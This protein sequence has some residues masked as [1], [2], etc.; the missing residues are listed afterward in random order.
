MIGHAHARSARPAR[1]GESWRAWAACRGV[2]TER[3]YPSAEA[4]EAIEG[5]RKVCD[6]CPVRP[7]CLEYALE[8]R[9]PYGVWGG[10][11]EDERRSLR[12]RRQAERRRAAAS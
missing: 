2:E 6:G 9:E 7:A 12:R 8:A 3:F 11:T 4:S 1:L 10:L 5:A